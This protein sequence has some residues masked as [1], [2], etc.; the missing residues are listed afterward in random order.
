[1]K[2]FK[3]AIKRYF[4]TGLLVIIPIWGTFLILTALLRKLEGLFGDFLKRYL[5]FYIPG[6]GIITLIAIILFVG[7]FATNIIGKKIVEWW[8]SILNRLPIV[9]SIYTTIKTILDT[10]SIQ[11]KENFNKVVLIQF[12]RKGQYSFAFLTGITRGEVQEVTHEKVVNVY[13]PTTPNPT[14]GYFLLVP[15]SEIIPL[16]MSVED[17]MKMIIS[18]GMFTPQHIQEKKDENKK[19]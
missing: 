17:G 12:P 15:E 6:F 1:M 19:E 4:F 3:K 7:L 13:V 9:R 5:V 10:V 8:D 18:G 2:R 14:S 16:S 11:G